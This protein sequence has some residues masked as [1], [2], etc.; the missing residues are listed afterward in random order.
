MFAM[1]RFG[2][3]LGSEVLLTLASLS[4][5][6]RCSPNLCLPACLRACHRVYNKPTVR[7][8]TAYPPPKCSCVHSHRRTAATRDGFSPVCVCQLHS[9][10]ERNEE[11][12]LR[13]R[14]SENLTVLHHFAFVCE[15]ATSE[16]TEK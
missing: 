2:S 7:S 1:Q 4:N 12:T 8:S 3:V 10:N 14:L 11:S 5:S 16:P 15:A 13:S 9:Y 6:S